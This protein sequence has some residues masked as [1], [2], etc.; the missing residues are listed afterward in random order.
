MPLALAGLFA[1]AALSGCLAEEGTGPPFT[2]T[3]WAQVNALFAGR[4]CQSCHPPSAR[5]L[6]TTRLDS[7]M[8]MRSSGT[9]TTHGGKLVEP[10]SKEQSCLWL[11]VTG[12]EGSTMLGAKFNT[13]DADLIGSWIDDGAVGP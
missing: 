12:R 5:Y 8:L 2:G 13:S 3:T 11:S 4:T 7:P 1:L 10:G 6:A 9:C